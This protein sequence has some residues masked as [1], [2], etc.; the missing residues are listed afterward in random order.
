MNAAT[1]IFLFF[2]VVT[3]K[4]LLYHLVGKNIKIVSLSLQL[5]AIIFFN[6]C[7]SGNNSVRLVYEH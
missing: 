2:R 1:I 7:K 6:H 4:F 5:V 3:L